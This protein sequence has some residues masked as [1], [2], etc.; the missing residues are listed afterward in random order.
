MPLTNRTN[1]A[2]DSSSAIP[3]LFTT[4]YDS[5]HSQYEGSGLQSSMTNCFSALPYVVAALSLTAIA[6]RV[7]KNYA[8][9]SH[10]RQREL[11]SLHSFRAANSL[12]LASGTFATAWLAIQAIG[13]AAIKTF[14]FT[15][16]FT[17]V[18]LGVLTAVALNYALHKIA[19][20]PNLSLKLLKS[21]S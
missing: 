9:Q 17:G 3:G 8:D 14:A 5:V 11:Q 19:L 18:W 2:A 6:G 13:L 12:I 15:L 16:M 4:W 1:Q 20:D 21:G 7:W 10:L